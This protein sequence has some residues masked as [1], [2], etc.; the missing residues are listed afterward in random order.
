V[1]ASMLAFLCTRLLCGAVPNAEVVHPFNVSR[2]VELGDA[3]TSS[4]S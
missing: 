4:L 3:D 2:A 1:L